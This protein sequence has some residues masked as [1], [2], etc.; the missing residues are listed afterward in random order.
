M[1]VLI[2]DIIGLAF[3][4]LGVTRPGETA[5]TAM[6]TQ[7]LMIL[8]QQWQL[9]SLEK[10]FGTNWYHQTFTLVAGT[11]VY[12]VGVGGTLVATADPVGIRSWRSVSGNFESAGDIISFDEFD[13]QW[14]NKN[15]E[16]SVLAKAVASDAS[17]PSKTIRVAPVPA[18][19]PG[20]LILTY[21][22]QMPAFAL[23]GDNAPTQPGYQ[24]FMHN[25][26]AIQLYPQYARAGAQSLQALA[27]N[28][29]AALGI[30]TAL[31]ADIMGLV[32]AP[33]PQQQGG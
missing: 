10:T 16:S 4:D 29:Q 30:I 25:D 32:Q 1:S 26:L 19:S 9:N 21:Y 20:S 12:T 5:T 27:A 33:A 31:N 6:S 15:A 22:A 24:S 14:Q 28:R 2:S 8:I 17:V 18:A 11:S 13:Q 7:A 23:L 3:N